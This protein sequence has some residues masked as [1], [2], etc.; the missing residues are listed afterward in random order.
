MDVRSVTHP[1]F[2]V[3]EPEEVVRVDEPEHA[4]GVDHDGA[5]DVRRVPDRVSALRGRERER[6]IGRHAALHR[7]R[8]AIELEDA[9]EEE[10]LRAVG[11]VRE[12][13]LV[14]I[15][16]RIGCHGSA[17]TKGLAC[18]QGAVGRAPRVAV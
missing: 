7:A 17:R 11:Q 2:V 13:G 1:P 12:E 10:D 14:E 15:E 5:G 16:R 8:V 9:I 3:A 4:G 18:A 6:T